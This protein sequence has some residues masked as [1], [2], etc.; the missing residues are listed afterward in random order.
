[1]K[2]D[3]AGKIAF[4]FG[5]TKG[6]G[7]AIALKLAESGADIV[8]N[9]RNAVDGTTVKEIEGLGRRV[10]FARADITKYQEVKDAVESALDH[11][12]K[13]DILVASGGVIGSD[14]LPR[15]FHETDPN[16]Y[17]TCAESQWLTR[18]RCLRAVMDHMIH[19][20]KGKI[21]VVT[22]DAGRWPTPAEAVSGG[23]AA[24]VIMGTKVIAQEVARYGI[25]VNAVSL[26]PIPNTEGYN[27]VV[28]HS[29][30]LAHVLKKAIDK[31]PFPV[32]A[33]DIAE[34]TLFLASDRSD[35]ITGQILSV[36]GGLCFPG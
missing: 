29:E 24:A 23:S 28:Q 20:G 9:G 31:Q 1:M 2:L 22:S 17:F 26:P 7:K 10:F 13:I 3:L 4:V 5:S 16:S 8:L 34:A 21:V 27:H 33:E 11:F 32:T 6:I 30:S 35:A 25:R 15:F 14:Y 19:R 36:N 18:L 12:G